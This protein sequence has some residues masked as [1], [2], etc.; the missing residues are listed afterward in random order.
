MLTIRAAGATAAIASERGGR[1]ASLVVGGRELLIGPWDDNDRSIRWGCYLMAPWPGRLANARFEW[2]GRV[3]HVPA[4]LEPHAIHGLVLARPWTV[5]SSAENA[6]ALACELPRDEW[7][8][9]G[10]VRERVTLEDGRL[11]LEA[12][13][14]AGDA[15]PAALGWHPWFDRRGMPVR[16]RVEADEVVETR[17][18]LPTGG[19]LPATGELDLH[20]G[21][22]LGDRRLDDA[23]V[24]AASPAVVEWPDLRLTIAFEPSPS[25]LVVYTPDHAV[26]VE[27]QTAL[28]NALALPRAEAAAAGIRLLAPGDAL[29]TRMTISWS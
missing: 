28:P 23:Y 8:M 16:L 15:M 18:M 17:D 14:E 3:V 21:P 9:G 5:T 27:P 24:A 1:L 13:I 26:C 10:I 25:C 7:P 19:R 12:S 29:S 20:D 6:A 11:T 4:T 22:E 2:D